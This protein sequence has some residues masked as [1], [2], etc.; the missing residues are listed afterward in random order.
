[1]KSGAVLADSTRPQPVHENAITIAAR[2]WFVD[3]LDSDALN[4]GSHGCALLLYFCVR[5]GILSELVFEGPMKAFRLSAFA[6]LLRKYR[7]LVLAGILLMLV[8]GC[9]VQRRKS[10]AELGLNPQQAAGRRLYDQYCDRCHEPY[11]SRD[12]K[13]RSLQGV[14]KKKFLSESGMPANDERVGEMIVTGRNMM[15][16][17]GQTMS[18]PQV[19]DLLAYLHTL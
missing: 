9:D 14:F 1:V 13:G 11:S 5:F 7:A 15:P 16:A 6:P 17:F 4:G 12:K 10:D 3:S 19:Q 18:Q 2:G 8:T